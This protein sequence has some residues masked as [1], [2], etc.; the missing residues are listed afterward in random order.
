[1][2]SVAERMN[3]KIVKGGEAEALINDPDFRGK[4]QSLYDDC[5]WATAMQGIAFVEIWYRVYVNLYE[6]HLL[7][8]YRGEELVGLFQLSIERSSGR[9]NVA[10][11]QYAEY[12]TWLAKSGFENSFIEQSLDLLSKEFR[13]QTLEFLFLASGSPLEWLSTSKKWNK[14]CDLR[15]EP[16]PLMDVT[17]DAIFTNSLRKK[18][19]KSRLKKLAQNGPLEF[20]QLTNYS[21]LEEVFDTVAVFGD[22]RLSATHSVVIERDPLKKKFYTELMKAGLIHATLLKAGPQ[23]VSAQIN[24][25]NGDEVLL[26]MSAHSPFLSQFSPSKFHIKFLGKQLCEENVTFF[27]LTPGGE[28]K[29]S[30]ATIY[31]DAHILTVFFSRNN[32]LRH[33]SKRKLVKFGLRVIKALGI[34]RDT[35][36]SRLRKIMWKLKKLRVS[37]LTNTIFRGI[38]TRLYDE[39]EF[40]IYS[41]DAEDIGLTSSVE[42]MNRNCIDD[43]LMYD[44]VE[45]WQPTPSEFHRHAIDRFTQ[46]LSVYTFSENGKLLHYGWLV[47]RQDK[48]FLSEVGQYFYPLPNSALLFDYYSHP[49]ARGRGLY[50][51]SLRQMLRD[52]ARIPNTERIYIGVLADNGPSRHVI[53]KAGFKYQYSFF[54]R[55]RLG[56]VQTWSTAPDDVTHARTRSG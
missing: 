1:M 52:A 48:S 41:L 18:S 40:R 55:V 39:R 30:H 21:Q 35:F 14:Q 22:L 5:P 27:D 3:I 19:N 2:G 45:S 11:A 54:K 31:E 8:G 4:W 32:Y 53:E 37:T 34:D 9:L 49:G 17:D 29:E 12:K 33:A 10:G 56:T 44:P 51:S 38:K 6:P 13:D 43:L 15:A 16:R 36:L 50:Q 42:L 28:Y 46:N 47:E 20:V 26:G 24:F 23:I 7:I 25:H